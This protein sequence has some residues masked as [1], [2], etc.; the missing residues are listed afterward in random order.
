MQHRLSRLCGKVHR[1]GALG[2]QHTFQIWPR[3]RHH[4]ISRKLRKGGKHLPGILFSGGLSRND[5]RTGI[6][7]L[8]CDPRKG[9]L[10]LHQF[11][12][13]A[14]VHKV[15]SFQRSEMHLAFVQDPSLGD[16]HLRHRKASSLILHHQ[17]RHDHL[18]GCG[19][20]IQTHAQKPLRHGLSPLP[21]P[22]AP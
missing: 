15:F 2:S 7:L 16:L 19:A 13:R 9:I 12:D 8:P 20:H 22:A 17:L 1:T 3:C 4:K 10:P 11:P 6:H 5:H 14:A 21:A 18:G